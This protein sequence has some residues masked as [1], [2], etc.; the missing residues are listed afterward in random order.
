MK[1][2]EVQLSVSQWR[3][4]SGWVYLHDVVECWELRKSEVDEWIEDV[5]RDSSDLFDYVTDQ[6]REWDSLPDYDETD[7]EW[8]MTIVEISEGGTEKILASTSV[9]ESELAKEWFN[10]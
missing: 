4:G 10:N 2:Y 3:E 8:T 9:W 6:F 1:K 5:K 7:N